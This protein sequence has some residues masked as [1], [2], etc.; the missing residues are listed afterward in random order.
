MDN[1]KTLYNKTISMK[2]IEKLDN[3]NKKELPA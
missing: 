1:I 2:P 3:N